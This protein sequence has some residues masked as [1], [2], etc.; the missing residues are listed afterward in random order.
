MGAEGY[1]GSS[2]CGYADIV[3]VAS[4]LCVYVYDARI[5]D[6][7][8]VFTEITRPTVAASNVDVIISGKWG[9]ARDYGER[10]IGDV[11]LCVEQC[12]RAHGAQSN[13]V[14]ELCNRGDD[15]LLRTALDD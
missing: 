8:D 11:I 15:V 14:V 12:T 5:R 9:K 7:G 6:V 3:I 2:D 1:Y 10:G 4:K 13:D